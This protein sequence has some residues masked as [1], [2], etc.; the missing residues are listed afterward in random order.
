M[1]KQVSCLLRRHPLLQKA[2]VLNFV[3]TASLHALLREFS[4]GAARRF[5]LKIMSS[6]ER[7]NAHGH[8]RSDKELRE[9]D[10]PLYP[11]DR[12]RFALQAPANARRP[13]SFLSQHLLPLG[14]TLAGTM[15]RS[16]SRSESVGR[17]GP[18][19]GKLR[20]LA[21]CGRPH[22]LGSG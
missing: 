21:R 15:P 7:E 13:I 6:T 12:R 22:V 8:R 19:R 3:P 11:R 1:N 14:A 5:P 2:V 17:W 9:L 16:P 20:H 18:S 10:A 4:D